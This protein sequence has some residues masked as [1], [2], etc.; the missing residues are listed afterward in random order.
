MSY[1][2]VIARAL[3]TP[4]VP[5]FCWMFSYIRATG[6]VSYDRVGMNK[7]STFLHF[8][9]R[10]YPP[11][12]WMGCPVLLLAFVQAICK[13]CTGLRLSGPEIK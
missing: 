9:I 2:P 13:I 4:R 5:V 3:V 6:A 8:L 7:D 12:S 1:V 10:M 11:G